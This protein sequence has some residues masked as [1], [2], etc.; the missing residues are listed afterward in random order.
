MQVQ[1]ITAYIRNSTSSSGSL[2]CCYFFSPIKVAWQVETHFRTIFLLCNVFVFSLSL[3]VG[4]FF[5]MSQTYTRTKH[6]PIEHLRHCST[7]AS[8][9]SMFKGMLHFQTKVACV[10]LQYTAWTHL[11]AY[12]HQKISKSEKFFDHM[13]ES[14]D[15][16]TG[17]LK[18]AELVPFR[19]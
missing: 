13:V 16:C 5:F 10:L 3:S 2:H 14:V 7:Q 1:Y 18:F 9:T 8:N 15:N 19:Y 4:E 17:T 6:R 11:R 12:L